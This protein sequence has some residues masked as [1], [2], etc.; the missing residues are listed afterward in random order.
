MVN[1]RVDDLAGRESD[2]GL[3]AT[4]DRPRLSPFRFEPRHRI[5]DL[6]L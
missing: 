1:C 4:L 2:D 5:R 6:V 3:E